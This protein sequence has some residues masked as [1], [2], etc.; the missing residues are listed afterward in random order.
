M[1]GYRQG[2]NPRQRLLLFSW[3]P[4]TGAA[5]IGH[6]LNATCGD[7]RVAVSQVVERDLRQTTPREHGVKCR[8]DALTAAKLVGEVAGIGRQADL[9]QAA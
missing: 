4:L 7:R 9:A 6:Q 8:S 5:F 2:T 1:K 3:G